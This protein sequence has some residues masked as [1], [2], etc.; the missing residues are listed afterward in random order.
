M[1]SVHTDGREA[2]C[3]QQENTEQQTKTL[4]IS[5][6]TAQFL[7]L[8]SPD[9]LQFSSTSVRTHVIN[10]V[11][12]RELGHMAQHQSPKAQY[13]HNQWGMMEYRAPNVDVA[14]ERLQIVSRRRPTCNGMRNTLS[15]SP[16]VP[17]LWWLSNGPR[18]VGAERDVTAK[19][20]K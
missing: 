13:Q 17:E 10:G 18:G 19:S 16:S 9:K 15:V 14:A 8:P 5:I 20:W 12:D 6:T 7:C 2:E 4:W 11:T 1:A 3:S